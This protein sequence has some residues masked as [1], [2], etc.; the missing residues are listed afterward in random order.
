MA[1][2]QTN[3]KMFCL[4]IFNQP[5]LNFLINLA[6]VGDIPQLPFLPLSWVDLC[7]RKDGVWLGRDVRLNIICTNCGC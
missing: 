2:K 6:I 1:K 5:T 7:D 4:V 3:K